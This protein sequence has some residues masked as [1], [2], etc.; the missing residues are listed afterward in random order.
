MA[1]TT[2]YTASSQCST[3]PRLYGQNFDLPTHLL[4]Q[5]GLHC[6][7]FYDGNVARLF[8]PW[9]IARG[10]LLPP[11]TWLP[12]STSEAW[13]LL[14]NSVSQLQRAVGILLL[15][16]VHGG[17]SR[18][19]CNEILNRMVDQAIQI[20]DVVCTCMDG[21]RRSTSRPRVLVPNIPHR[22][23]PTAQV[24]LTHGTMQALAD[25]NPCQLRRRR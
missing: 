14:G 25:V 9:E 8:S 4:S 2:R 23:T 17:R 21:T 18:V 5:F 12:S 11:S 7:L 3:I 22:Q 20:Q 1:S 16:Q 15:D 13:A 19:E 10:L 6:P 24:A